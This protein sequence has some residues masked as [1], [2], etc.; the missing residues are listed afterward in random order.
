MQD[1]KIIIG[2]LQHSPTLGQ[3]M[4]VSKKSESELE[5]QRRLGHRIRSIRDRLQL[6]RNQVADTL[7]TNELMVQRL[8]NGTAILTVTRLLKLAEAFRID[9]AELLRSF[10]DWEAQEPAPIPAE[11]TPEESRLL[12]AFHRIQDKVQRRNIL[13]LM[14]RMA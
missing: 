1:R 10:S 3:F 4:A 2:D 14:E 13:E 12:R 11:L 7:G 5:D 9:P 6:T 8:E